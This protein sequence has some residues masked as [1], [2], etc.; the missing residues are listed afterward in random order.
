MAGDRLLVHGEALDCEPAI[1]QR[2]E[3]EI[4][5]R[6][7]LTAQR[8]EAEEVLRERDLVRE[9]LLDGSDDAVA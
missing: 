6:V 9:A 5:D 3:D 1:A 7:L 2:A 4:L 8:A